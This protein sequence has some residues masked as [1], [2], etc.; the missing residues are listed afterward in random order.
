MRCPKCNI[1]IEKEDKGCQAVRCFY[2]KLD[3]CW[4]TKKPRW[5]P[6]VNKT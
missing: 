1:L 3:I 2:C 4:L 5:G 6:S